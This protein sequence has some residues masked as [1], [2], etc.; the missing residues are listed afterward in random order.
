MKGRCGNCRF[1]CGLEQEKPPYRHINQA[2]GQVEVHYH[3]APGECRIG[4]PYWNRWPAT[5][6]RD[7]CGEFEPIPENGG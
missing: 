1:W 4:R 5:T 3:C 7:W 6:S 2:T